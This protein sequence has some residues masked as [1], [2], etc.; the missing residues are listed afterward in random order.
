HSE[1]VRSPKLDFRMAQFPIR[2]MPPIY[3]NAQY[4]RLKIVPIKCRVILAQASLLW[5]RRSHYQTMGSLDLRERPA[6]R[7]GH[8]MCAS[9]HSIIWSGCSKKLLPSKHRLKPGASACADIP[10]SSRRNM[11]VYGI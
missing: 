1:N 9:N 7:T 4:G 2:A 6:L 11:T 5:V 3:P 10:K 8:P